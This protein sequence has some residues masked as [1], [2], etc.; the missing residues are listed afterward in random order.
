[1]GSKRRKSA[2]CCC[3]RCLF[4]DPQ[5]RKKQYETRIKMW[6]IGKKT[7]KEEREHMIRISKRRMEQEGKETQFTIRGNRIDPK[8]VDRASQAAKRHRQDLPVVAP[9]ASSPPGK[10]LVAEFLMLAIGG[11]RSPLSDSYTSRNRVQNSTRR[12]CKRRPSANRSH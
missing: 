4:T 1:M 11:C 9:P 5:K 2:Q 3:T 8:R 7:T 10:S 12:R 6:N